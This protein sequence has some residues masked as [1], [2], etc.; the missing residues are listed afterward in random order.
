LLTQPEIERIAQD[1]HDEAERRSYVARILAPEFRSDPRSWELLLE[2]IEVVLH[3]RDLYIA[4]QHR[5]EGLV[6]AR[7]ALRD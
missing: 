5:I 6:H 3:K 7:T 1:L 4:P 2:M